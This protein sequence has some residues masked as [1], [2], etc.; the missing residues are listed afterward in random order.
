MGAKTVIAVD[1]G[2]VEESNLYNYGDSLNGFWVLWNK[3]N[4]W[5]LPV[6]VLNMEEIQVCNFKKL[7]FISS[8]ESRLAYV[9]CVRQLEI[10]KKAPYCQYLRP[11]IDPYK[12]LDFHHFNIINVR[13]KHLKKYF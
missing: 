12:T 3:W 13:F 11:A 7:H 9:S 4:P 8:F 10:V 1:V 6:R 5:A 2:S